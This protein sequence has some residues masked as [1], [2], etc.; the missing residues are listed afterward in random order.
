MYIFTFQLFCIGGFVHLLDY[1]IVILY[2]LSVVLLGFYFHKQASRNIEAYFLGDKNL[3]WWALGASG[4]ASNV[5]LSGTMILTALI[6]ALGTKGF[7]IEIRG[8][9]VLIMAFFMIFMG[10]WNRRSECMTVAEWMKFRFGDNQQGKIARL[11]SAIANIVFAIGTI[12]YFAIGGGKFFSEFFGISEQTGTIILIL[13][14]TIYTMASGLYG[15]VW[16]DVF[17]GFLIFIGVIVVVFIAT[18]TVDLPQ[19]FS[20]SV[21]IE[22]KFQQLRIDYNDWSS[23]LPSWKLNLPGDYSIYNLFGFTIILYLIKTLLEG[24]SGSGGYITQRYFAAKNDREAGLL[25]LFWIILL[26]F[27]WPLIAAFAVLGIHYGITNTVI[28][29]P[30][31]VVPVVIKTYLPPFFKGIVITGFL[32]AAMSTFTS[33]INAAAAYWVKDIYLEYINKNASNKLQVIHSKAASGLIVLLGVLFASSLKSINEIWGW[34]SLGLGSGLALPLVLRWFWWRFNGYGFAFGTLAGMI[35]AIVL[36]LFFHNLLEAYNFFIPITF[37]LIG[38]LLGT[39]LTPKIETDILKNFYLKTKPFGFWKPI[40]NDI[41]KNELAII[42]KENKRDLISIMLAIP[43]QFFLFMLGMMLILKRWDNVLILVVLVTLL[44][45]FL[46]L[47]WF[48]Y[49][50]KQDRT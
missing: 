23:L 26:S 48:R 38:C 19:S 9:I 33:V 8:G 13:I 20:V 1:S 12:S 24:F 36:K 27:R 3:P 7:F 29:D 22:G 5:D 37:S 47:S 44:S 21:P 10:K 4:M 49:L 31:L 42:V 14:T 28:S 30:E 50:S 11:I 35:A 45:I 41:D 16:T 17:Q 15:V 25:S 18:T 40:K 34:L 43:W 6:F 39:F 2:L 46:Y 32:A